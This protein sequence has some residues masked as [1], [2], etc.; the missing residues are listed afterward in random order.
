MKQEPA[1]INVYIAC[2]TLRSTMPNNQVL[3][4]FPYSREKSLY[5][6]TIIKGKLFSYGDKKGLNPMHLFQPVVL[7]KLSHGTV[8][9]F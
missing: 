6:S 5:K 4:H 1:E 2:I 8:W 7:V 3:D 9:V